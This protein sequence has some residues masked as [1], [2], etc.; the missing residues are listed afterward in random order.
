MSLWYTENV[1]ITW[2]RRMKKVFCILFTILLVCLCGCNAA[3][4]NTSTV[5]DIGG[6]SGDDVRTKYK[7]YQYFELV[8]NPEQFV[9]QEAFFEGEI[10]SFALSASGSVSYRL[11][12]YDGGTVYVT[13]PSFYTFRSG[14]GVAVY[15]K[16]NGLYGD[17]PGA[18]P[19][20]EAAFIEART[21]VT[22]IFLYPSMELIEGESDTVSYD[23]YPRNV[24]DKTL[25][26]TSEDESV[27]KV[28]DSGSVTA[29][30]AGSTVI[31]A[32]SSNGVSDTIRV[33]V[34][35]KSTL[36]VPGL[37][38]KLDLYDADHHVVMQEWYIT[39]FSYWFTA[40]PDGKVT[41][42]VTFNGDKRSDNGGLVGSIVNITYELTDQ[43]AYYYPGDIQ[44]GP[45]VTRD[46]FDDQT[47]V[48]YGLEPGSYSLSFTGISLVQGRIP[49]F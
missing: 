6:H 46:L 43:G 35:K 39:G 22:R 45:V 29:V 10:V 41:L 37:P 2:G 38:V 49:I 23:I 25:K 33:T 17:G 7:T 4:T 30:K 44:V 14:D 11:S 13:S 19:M 26:W 1:I 48:F 27:A 9:G 16:L 32:E 47:I 5:P 18:I 34:L 15:G 20:I 28:D 31:K 12:V 3:K 42:T 40:A 8:Q 21:D 24:A 36:T